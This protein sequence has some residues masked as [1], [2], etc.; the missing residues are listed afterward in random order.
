ME[1]GVQATVTRGLNVND[2]RPTTPASQAPPLGDGLMTVMKK[3]E[4][5][6]EK[7]AST[8]ANE[9]IKQKQMSAIHEE[10]TKKVSNFANGFIPLRKIDSKYD[11]SR[12]FK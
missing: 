6:E 10:Q 7:M 8:I 9:N 4:A 3:K 11:V 1:K 12:I 2:S 5:Y